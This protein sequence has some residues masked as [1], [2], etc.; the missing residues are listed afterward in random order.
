VLAPNIIRT[1]GSLIHR[2][3]LVRRVVEVR[4]DELTPLQQ[5]RL[6]LEVDGLGDQLGAI[7]ERL[8]GADVVEPVAN[9]AVGSGEV[10]A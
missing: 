5:S 2:A 6:L 1:L 8:T 3:T 9:L 4:H 7:H 10:R